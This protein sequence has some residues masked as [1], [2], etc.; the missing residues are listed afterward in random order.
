MFPAM[1][2]SLRFAA[3]KVDLAEGGKGRAHAM[4][5]VLE[6]GTFLLELRDYSVY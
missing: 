2:C 6:A 3:L 4:Q 5:F 1:G